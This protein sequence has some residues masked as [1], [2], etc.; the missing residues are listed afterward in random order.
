ML[1]ASPEAHSHEDKDRKLKKMV[2]RKKINGMGRKSEV[3]ANAY[4]LFNIYKFPYD[5]KSCLKTRF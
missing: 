3:S 4:F 1:P 2:V 5:N